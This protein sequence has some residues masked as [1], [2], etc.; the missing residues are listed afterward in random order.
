MPR[1]D[2][3]VYVFATLAVVF[4]AIAGWII[5]SSVQSTLRR[6]H[7]SPRIDVSSQRSEDSIIELDEAVTIASEHGSGPLREIE[8][9]WDGDQL[10]YEVEIGLT[11]IVLD[12]AHGTLLSITDRIEADCPDCTIDIERAEPP[13]TM[14]QAIAAAQA[15]VDGIATEVEFMVDQDGPIYTI[16]IRR[17]KVIV[18]ATS[19]LVLA[20]MVDG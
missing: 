11:T 13:I 5:V 18:S 4:A 6:E 12:A 14:K 7:V 3:P 10:V 8:I 17:Q 16:D 19:G 2:R 20:V 9:E 1:Q 15:E